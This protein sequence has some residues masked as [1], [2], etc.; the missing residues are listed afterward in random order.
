MAFLDNNNVVVR[1]IAAAVPANSV[2]VKDIYR[3]EWGDAD[4]F[5]NATTI[6]RLRVSLPGQ[7]ASDL[8]VASAE[9]LLDELHWEKD[10]V[11]AIIFVTQ[12]P[13]FY[14]VPATACHIQYRLGLPKSCLAFDI[15]LGCSGFVYGL[16]TLSTLLNSGSIKRALLLVGDT[17]TK[18]GNPN[19]P[20]IAPLFGD[21]GTATALEYDS[22]RS[23]AGIKSVLYTDGDGYDAIICPEGAFRTPVTAES[24]PGFELHVG[25]EKSV[26]PPFCIVMDGVSVFTFAISQAPKSIKA[27]IEQFNIDRDTVDILALHQA[28]LMINEKII[29]KAKLANAKSPQSM[30]D[31]GNTAGA[32]IPLSLVTEA[33][34]TLRDN[35]QKIIACGFGVGLSW[36][37]TYFET[38]HITVPQLIEI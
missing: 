12:T 5:I 18:M 11:E 8:C 26:R 33:A 22:G 4:A 7:T 3:P 17:P 31:F 38:D 19:D 25:E 32:S 28:N 34:D 27:L 23:T 6:E 29:K 20:S 24:F 1:G 30:R 10:S 16:A 15:T 14:F 36:G 35:K 2:E 9:K 21:V 37:A 13:D